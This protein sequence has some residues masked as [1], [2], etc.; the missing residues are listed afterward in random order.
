MIEK[1]AEKP[2]WLEL[3]LGILAGLTGPSGIF[4]WIN[5]RQRRFTKLAAARLAK[6]EREHDTDRT[7]SGLLPDGTNPP[8]DMA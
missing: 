3:S 1:M 4:F 6:F 2:A 5:R 8:E 7:S